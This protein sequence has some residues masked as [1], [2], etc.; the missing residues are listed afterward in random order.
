MGFTVVCACV[1]ECAREKAML[2][3]WLCAG[4]STSRV[5][6]CTLSPFVHLC[7]YLKSG[8]VYVHIQTCRMICAAHVPVSL[9]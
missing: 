9:T 2:Y 5:C 7:W 4:V 1:C 3:V 8:V 6:A